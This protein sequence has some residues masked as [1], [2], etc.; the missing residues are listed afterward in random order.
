[1][2]FYSALVAIA[3]M[4]GNAAAFSAV[5]PG[6]PAAAPAATDGGAANMEPVDKT[7][8]GIDKE[9]GFEPTEGDNA[10]L[11]RNNKGE[12]WNEQVRSL[13][14]CALLYFLWGYF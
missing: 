7:M 14:I 6:K 8:K 3:L 13:R 11:K 1:M 9:P 5:A 2:K 12:V 4:A 10:A